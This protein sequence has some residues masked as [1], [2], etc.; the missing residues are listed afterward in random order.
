MA[1]PHCARTL[2]SDSAVGFFRK[3]LEVRR[4]RRNGSDTDCPGSTDLADRSVLVESSSHQE[5]ERR[6]GNC[7]GMSV[8]R[9]CTSV[10]S[11]A[12]WSASRSFLYRRFEPNNGVP[13]QFNNTSLAARG[14]SE[15]G[16]TE[17]R[18][19]EFGRLVQ[20]VF[21]AAAPFLA[22]TRIQSFPKIPRGPAV[23]V[24][25][26]ADHTAEEPFRW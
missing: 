11:E 15:S 24:T 4:K 6:L 13:R 18:P 7:L 9:V 19:V 22:P 12:S 17:E 5:P 3:F 2:S 25:L 10:C 8:A 21:H 1:L 16:I 20:S 14:E 26:C 23:G